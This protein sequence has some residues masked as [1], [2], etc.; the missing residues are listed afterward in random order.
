MKDIADVKGGKR[1]PAGRQLLDKNNGYIY[2]RVSD[3]KNNT[4]STNSLKY[5]PLDIMPLIKNYTISKEDLYLTIAGTIGKAGI[6]PSVF[7][8]MNLT[9]NAVKIC[10][11]KINKEYLMFL[12][13]SKYMQ[14]LFSEKTNKVA[15]PK[16]AIDKILSCVVPIPPINEQIRI[17]KSI[18]YLLSITEKAEI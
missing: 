2:I 4:I 12:I 17:V 6:V 14:D 15:Q 9:E 1:I 10:N 11:I 16:L 8:G 7:D 5:V 18:K 3:M 13:T